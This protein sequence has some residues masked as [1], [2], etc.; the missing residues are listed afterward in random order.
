MSKPTAKQM[1]E[2]A[3]ALRQAAMLICGDCGIAALVLVQAQAQQE[4]HV[5]S[6]H[7]IDA[8]MRERFEADVARM[9][10]AATR[11]LEKVRAMDEAEIRT[12]AAGGSC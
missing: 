4:A 8:G 5:L 6:E 9:K 3:T 7:V 12:N 1:T 11:G 2:M 10:A